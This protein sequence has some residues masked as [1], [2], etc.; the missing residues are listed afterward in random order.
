MVKK[1]PRC[2]AER[3]LEVTVELFNRFVEP[4]V[5]A[6]RTSVQLRINRGNRCLLYPFKDES[7]SALF[8]LIWHTRNGL[9]STN[10]RLATHFQPIVNKQTRA[11]REILGGMGRTALCT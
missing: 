2:P 7:I 6:T 9:R 11:V 3:I 10:R 4:I 8:E 5:S 1:V